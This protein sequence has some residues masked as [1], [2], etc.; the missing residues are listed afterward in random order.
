MGGGWALGS[1][2]SLKHVYWTTQGGTAR[3]RG[4]R[5]A[6]LLNQLDLAN[7]FKCNK[8]LTSGKNNLKGKADRALHRWLDQEIEIEMPFFFFLNEPFKG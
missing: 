2:L 3:G 1:H 4:Q 7:V 6:I 5:N 8:I